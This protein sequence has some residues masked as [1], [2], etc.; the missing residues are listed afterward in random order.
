MF[1]YIQ[2][3][4]TWKGYEN[5]HLKSYTHNDIALRPEYLQNTVHWSEP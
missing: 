1:N 5:K 2:L 4:K 3:K